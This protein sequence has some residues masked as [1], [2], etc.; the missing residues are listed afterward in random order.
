MGVVEPVRQRFGVSN[1]YLLL[2]KINGI[3][4][5]ALPNIVAKLD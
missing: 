1:L 3:V 4:E 5:K 2:T